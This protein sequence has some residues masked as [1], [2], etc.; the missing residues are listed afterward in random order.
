MHPINKK[1]F[2]TEGIAVKFFNGTATV[3]G[4]IVK[5]LGTDRFVVSDGVH[6]VTAYLVDTYALATSLGESSIVAPP[7]G[8]TTSGAYQ[9]TI[10]VP[11]SS[12]TGYV[13]HIYDTQIDV[14]NSSNVLTR[15]SW[16][17]NTASDG[18][19]ALLSYQ[20]VYDAANAPVYSAGTHGGPTTMTFATAPVSASH[21]TSHAVVVA[22]SPVAPSSYTAEL[23]LTTS[24]T[25]LPTTGGI[26]NSSYADGNF[27]FTLSYPSVGTYYAFVTLS[28]TSY[29]VS[30][31]LVIS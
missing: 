19:V 2:G 22:T 31:A 9:M 13:R 10:P 15:E 8:N 17:L 3:S 1:F 24:A 25:V 5:Q 29:L 16:S 23:Y 28:D 21:G 14:F 4:Y 30:S 26:V 27:G 11:F 20:T 12:P 6:T 7:D 18:T